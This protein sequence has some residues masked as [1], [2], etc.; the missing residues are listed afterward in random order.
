[1]D[2]REKVAILP[3]K[4]TANYNPGVGTGRMWRAKRNP[5]FFSERKKY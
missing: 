1:L 2:F 4:Y 3:T 5:S